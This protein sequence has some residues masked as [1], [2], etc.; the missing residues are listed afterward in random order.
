MSSSD[1]LPTLLRAA[2][3]IVIFW[4]L[5]L[6]IRSWWRKRRSENGGPVGG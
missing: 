3:A 5:A 1:I 2:P 6:S 4:L